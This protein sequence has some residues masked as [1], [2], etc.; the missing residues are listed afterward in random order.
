MQSLLVTCLFH[1][2]CIRKFTSMSSNFS[3]DTIFLQ[4]ARRFA[5]FGMLQ[6]L[7]RRMKISESLQQVKAVLSMWRTDWTL[8]CAICKLMSSGISSTLWSSGLANKPHTKR[9]FLGTFP[10]TTILN[11]SALRATRT[12]QHETP[13]H[14]SSRNKSPLVVLHSDFLQHVCVYMLVLLCWHLH[15]RSANPNN[16]PFAGADPAGYYEVNSER[17]TKLVEGKNLEDLVDMGGVS[18]FRSSQVFVSRLHSNG[19]EWIE[20]GCVHCCMRHT[21]FLEV[22]KR[23]GKSRRIG[24][25]LTMPVS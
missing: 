2:A 24:D 25:V 6:T 22:Y 14:D 17:L 4:A 1:P 20:S 13:V 10:K 16:L 7:S 9:D 19:S 23:R 3:D 12:C 8:A 5:H 21:K 11:G 18:A 15:Q